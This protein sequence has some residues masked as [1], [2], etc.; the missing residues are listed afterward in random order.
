MTL[1]LVTDDRATR[2]A[3]LATI[4]ELIGAGLA[5][6]DTYDDDIFVVDAP[7]RVQLDNADVALDVLGASFRQVGPLGVWAPRIECHLPREVRRELGLDL[8]GA[9]RLLTPLC[10]RGA[11]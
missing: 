1:R 10:S 8:P 5:G 11:N 4:R 3:A 2:A 9:P 7:T 6:V